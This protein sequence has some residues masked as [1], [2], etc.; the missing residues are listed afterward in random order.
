[1][2]MS[3]LKVAATTTL[4]VAG[5]SMAAQAGPVVYYMK[6]EVGTHHTFSVPVGIQEALENDKGMQI[7]C[8]A[9]GVGSY[10]R[11]AVGRSWLIVRDVAFN[12]EVPIQLTIAG[13]Q[14]FFAVPFAA[15]APYDYNRV[16]STGYGWRK[17][18]YP[19]LHTNKIAQVEIS[20][21][22][23][24]HSA[25]G[26]FCYDSSFLSGYQAHVAQLNGVMACYPLKMTGTLL[27]S[28]YETVN[29]TQEAY[30]GTSTLTLTAHTKL[31][32]LVAGYTD[33]EKDPDTGI[34]YTP[35]NIAYATY[36][37]ANW[38]L[39]SGY[40]PAPLHQK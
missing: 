14:K 16:V 24:A 9:S 21:Y 33:D 34:V 40:Q 27:T 39:D 13:K 8:E 28:N 35:G 31:T 6:K 12:V 17:R 4:V 30:Y 19:V 25:S 11:Q 32:K 7:S 36:Q 29:G 18:L 23:Q 1:M 38:L 10:F 2:K 20:G 3:N 37:A 5:L 22:S 15:E 26:H